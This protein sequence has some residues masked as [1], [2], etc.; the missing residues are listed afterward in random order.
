M[1]AVWPDTAVTD[2]SLAQ[3]MVEI[4]RALSDEMQQLIRTVARQGYIFA[5]PVTTPVVEFPPRS[6]GARTES[7]RLPA[8]PTPVR[9]VNRRYGLRAGAL[10]LAALALAAGSVLMMWQVRRSAA[11][12]RLEYTQLTN[13]ADSATSP[14]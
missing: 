1:D 7:L 12:A 8:T 3:C 9:K 2:N 14:A 13:F 10:V 5:A 4:R 6:T 11:P